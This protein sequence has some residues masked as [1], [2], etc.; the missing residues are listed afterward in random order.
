MPTPGPSDYTPTLPPVGVQYSILGKHSGIQEKIA[1]PP[2]IY[3]VRNVDLVYN[4]TPHWSI[5][6]RL[7]LPKSKFVTPSPAAYA[8]GILNNIVSG[9]GAGCTLSGI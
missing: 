5:G 7:E 1:G 4:A 8:E 3:D 6:R 2:M 9:T